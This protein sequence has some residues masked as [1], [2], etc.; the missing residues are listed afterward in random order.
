MARIKNGSTTSNNLASIICTNIVPID[1]P[2]K[3][4]INDSLIL[5]KSTIPLRTKYK[6]AKKLPPHACSLLVPNAAAGGNPAHINA[7][8]V[9]KPPPPAI[10][11]INPATRATKNKITAS[12]SVSSSMESLVIRNSVKSADII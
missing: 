1:A 11:S 2:I 6:L 9:S 4:H 5:R 8:M 12:W 7:G 3:A 10:E